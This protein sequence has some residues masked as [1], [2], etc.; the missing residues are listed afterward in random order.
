[1]TE[2]SLCAAGGQQWNSL[3][4]HIPPEGE[5]K[6]N[7]LQYC[8]QCKHICRWSSKE[9]GG[10]MKNFSVLQV[11]EYLDLSL[12]SLTKATKKPMSPAVNSLCDQVVGRS[13]ISTAFSDFL[14][15]QEDITALVAF[16]SQ[17]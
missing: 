14:Q 6:E 16:R 10:S 12:K 1:M 5:R 11:M 9:Y 2:N 3:A 4:D 15:T 8:L 13:F 17:L 7:Q